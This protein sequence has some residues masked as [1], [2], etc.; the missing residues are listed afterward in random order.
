[1]KIVWLI[2]AGIWGFIGFTIWGIILGLFSKDL[3]ANFK[4][5]AAYY[6]DPQSQTVEAGQVGDSVLNILF[7]FF[8]GLA[9]VVQGFV[10][11]I[12]L[13]LF[14]KELG[15]SLKDNA[16]AGLS[17]ATNKWSAKA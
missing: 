7:I 4:G 5:M 3:G 10:W 6:M 15:A 9:F 17:V 8:G 1:M 14:D 2:F 13:G 11:G 12:V 16:M